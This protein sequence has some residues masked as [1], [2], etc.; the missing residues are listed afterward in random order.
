MNKGVFDLEKGKLS[1]PPKPDPNATTIVTTR[2][3]MTDLV[4]KDLGNFPNSKTLHCGGAGYKV[5]CVIDGKADCYLYPRDGTKRWDT[6]APEALL[7]SLGGTITDIF[8]NE[9]SYLKNEQTLVENCYGIIA[10]LNKENSFYTSKLSEE[11][12]S[13]V[14][15]AAKLLESKL[16]P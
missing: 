4:R 3:H 16:K 10:S 13:N 15:Q 14:K 2:S 1:V 6:C 11:L 7:R 5:L 9:Y 12:K 8:N